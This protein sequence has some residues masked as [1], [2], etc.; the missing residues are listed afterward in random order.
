MPLSGPQ[1]ALGAPGKKAADLAIEEIRQAIKK[2]K[3]DHKVTIRHVNDRS[4]PQTSVGARRRSRARGGE[5]AWPGPWSTANVIGVANTVSVPKKV[6]DDHAGLKQRRARQAAG[7]RVPEPHGR[8]P[9]T[10]RARRSLR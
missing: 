7:G 4:D 1:Q 5:S 2:A 10:F 9:T 6:L 3:A 8:R